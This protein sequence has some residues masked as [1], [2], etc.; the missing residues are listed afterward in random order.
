MHDGHHRFKPFSETSGQDARSVKIVNA[1]KPHVPPT[2]PGPDGSPGPEGVLV[3]VVV[4]SGLR[5]EQEDRPIA[6]SLASRVRE[7]LGRRPAPTRARSI[8]CSDIWFLNDESL[9]EVPVISIGGPESNALTAYLGDK[10]PPALAIDGALIVQ[11]DLSFERLQACCWGSNS[12]GTEAAADAFARK[13]LD[14]F[15]LAARRACV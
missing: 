15:L 7:R 9:R 3:L 4:G 6:Y 13:Y 1:P 5:A 2:P 14:P 8:V 11:A 12:K 10:I